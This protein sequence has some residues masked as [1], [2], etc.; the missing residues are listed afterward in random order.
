MEHGS[1][2][3]LSYR[4]NKHSNISDFEKG[5][6]ATSFLYHLFY[7]QEEDPE[8]RV[9]EARTYDASIRLKNILKTTFADFQQKKIQCG[10]IFVTIIKIEDTF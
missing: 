3:N 5:L 6:Q 2:L 9:Y 1:S 8:A 7:R 4:T 10:E